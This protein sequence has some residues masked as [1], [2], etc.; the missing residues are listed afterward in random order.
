MKSIIIITSVMLGFLLTT[1]F[2]T[3][4]ADEIKPEAAQG[5]YKGKLT[6]ISGRGAKDF[7]FEIDIVK[8]DLS[9]GRF[10]VKVT[11]DFYPNREIIRKNCVIDSGNPS[12]AFS[13]KGENWYENYEIH[14]DTIKA[15][16]TN[17]KN[18]SYYISA[19]KVK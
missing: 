5:L 7:D 4:A 15:K 2:T 18:I 3:H 14:D 1:T 11:S 12:L 10:V 9:T 8:I 16:A 13:C 6:F 17:V 19:T